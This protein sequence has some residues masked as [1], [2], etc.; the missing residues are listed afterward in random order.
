ME[1]GA[2]LL[3]ISDCGFENSKFEIIYMQSSVVCPLSS[4]F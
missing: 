3:R 2:K 4:D 1:H